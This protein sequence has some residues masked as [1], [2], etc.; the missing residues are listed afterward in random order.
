MTPVIPGGEA[1][2]AEVPASVASTGLRLIR[3]GRDGARK[4]ATSAC[5]GPDIFAAIKV[6]RTRHVHVTGQPGAGKSS[7]LHALVVDDLEAGRGVL[8]LD[9]H[10]SL[11]NG[12]V[13]SAEAGGR[14]GTSSWLTPPTRSSPLPWTSWL[15]EGPPRRTEPSSS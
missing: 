7:L 4:T 12:D 8:V 13:A 2:E 10:G 5:A 11:V 1:V 14:P 9:P 15:P 3:G 6:A